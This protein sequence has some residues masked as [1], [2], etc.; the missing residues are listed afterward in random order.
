[1]SPVVYVLFEPS[2]GS[3]GVAARL[4][5]D[6]LRAIGFRATVWPYTR[7]LPRLPTDA[8]VLHAAFGFRFSPLP[9]VRNI[10]IP[11]HEWDRYPP[12]WS[13]RLNAFDQVWA[14]TPYLAK[15]LTSSGV[16][17]PVHVVPP[18]LTLAPPRPKTRW[19]SRGPFRFLF[20]GEPHFRKGHHLLIE[21]FRRLDVSAQRATLTIKTSPACAWSADDQRITIIARHWSPAAMGQLYAA[22]D[23]F[24]SASLGEGLGMGVAEAVLAS[25]PVAVNYWGGHTALVTT[26]GFVRIAHRV[27]PQPFCSQPDFFA[28]GQRCAFSAPDSVAEAMDR[29]LSMNAADRRAQAELALATLRARFGLDVCADRLRRALQDPGEEIADLTMGATG[30]DAR[31]PRRQRRE[32]R[33]G[34]HVRRA[35]H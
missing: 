22:H 6:T 5:R 3:Y 29:L 15:V 1:M 20:V 16:S 10:A 35:D 34:N 18:A 31:R 24:V 7:P 11:F 8:T 23:A 32:V 19:S 14:A 13:A 2:V 27:M 17:R 21:A 26:G 30:E 33:N 12:A 9:G 4:Y 25:L 28:A